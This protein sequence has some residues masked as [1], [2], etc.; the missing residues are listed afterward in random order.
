VRV[1]L[2]LLL[3]LFVP[4]SAAPRA[5]AVPVL[6]SGFDARTREA[7]A[8][9]ALVENFLAQELARDR[10]L[11]V[12]RVEDTPAFTDYSARTY[13]KGCPEG[14]SAGCTLVIAQRGE[15][16][17]AVTGSVSADAE[18]SQVTVDIL[19]VTGS[20]VVLSF[21]T[22]LQSGSD[23]TFAAGVARVLVAAIGGEFAERD[24]RARDAEEE[25]VLD[26]AAVARQ[27]EDL[28]RE[29]GDMTAVVV[30]NDRL[31]EPPAYTLEDLARDVREEGGSPWERL[32]MDAEEYLRFKNSGLPLV[33]WRALALGRAGEV[34]VRPFLGYRTGPWSGSYFGRYAY[35][36]SGGSLVV[37]DALAYQAV[38]S[39][40]GGV[41]GASV[42]YGVLPWL[43]VGVVMGGATGSYSTDIDQQTVG[44]PDGI[45]EPD[46]RLESSLFFGPR[47]VAAFLPTRSLRPVA[48]AGLL[49]SLGPTVRDHVELP[50]ELPSWPAP[51]LAS[52]ELIVGGEARLGEWLDLYAHVPI[53]VGVAGT[54]TRSFRETTTQVLSDVAPPTASRVGIGA[55]IGLQLRLGGRA[56]RATSRFDELEAQEPDE[57]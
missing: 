48:G 13:M 32:G 6:V 12:L 29:L 37:V 47:A 8:L 49:F 50:P 19:D 1:L 22:E 44:Q 16:R 52:V 20:R 51:V 39:S 10:G 5:E 28:S 11:S 25:P 2:S 46:V 3:P 35:D 27:L 14:E 56:P 26:D 33:E 53:D 18:G 54:Y 40:G 15:A 4:A 41:F 7:A 43:D 23:E 38:Q 21:Q 57:E 24:I 17:W 45:V 55:E 9:A 30:R 36:V 34:L 42:G 31:V